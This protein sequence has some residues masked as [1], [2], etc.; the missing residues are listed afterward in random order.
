M[1]VVVEAQLHTLLTLELEGGER[2][3]SWSSRF[4]PPPENNPR[5]PIYRPWVGV[6]YEMDVMEER[7]ISYHHRG[8]E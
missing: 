5:Y 8:I 7:K 2:S 6:K 4:S 1:Y 3:A